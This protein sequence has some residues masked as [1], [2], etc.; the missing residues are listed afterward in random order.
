MDEG[1]ARVEERSA[2]AP[3]KPC[4]ECGVA[5]GYE[6]MGPFRKLCMACGALLKNRDVEA[7]DGPE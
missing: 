7:T 4:P 2:L 6:P 1:R 5:A 3:K